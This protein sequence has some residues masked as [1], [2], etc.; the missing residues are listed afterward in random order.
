M[1]LQD[2]SILFQALV[3]DNQDPLMLGRIRAVRLIDNIDDVLKSIRNPDWN[4][5]KDLWTIRDPFVWAPLI[6][7]FNY[8]VPKVDELVLGLF[9]NSDVKYVNQYY[10]QS[11]FYSPTATGFQYYQGA[12]KFTATGVQ[13]A[14]PKPL[15]TF[16]PSGVTYSDK[17][18]HKGV[19][20]EPTDNSV[21]GRGSAD[22][23]VKEE[24]V[25]I[26]A[27][28]FKGATLQPNVVPTANQ[29]RAF[30]Q[31]SRFPKSTIDNPPKTAVELKEVVVGVN[32]LIEYNILNPENVQDKFTGRISLYQLG[33]GTET[34]SIQLTVDSKVPDSLKS[35]VLYE[36]F[37]ALSSG[38]TIN[39]INDFIKNCN[40]NNTSKTTGKVLFPNSTLKFPFYYRPDNS[41]YNLMVSPDSDVPKLR[42]YGTQFCALFSCSIDIKVVNIETSEIVISK[43]SVGNES[44]LNQ[45][46]NDVIQQVT[47][48]LTSNGYSL[49][50]LPTINQLDGTLIPP[51]P[52]N[53]QVIKR[54]LTSI[55]NGIK[56]NPAMVP[57]F[58]L[59]YAQGKTGPIIDN[60]TRK[61]QSQKTIVSQNTVAALG[62]DK[63]YLLSHTSQIPGKGK[64][65]FDDTLYGI[66]SE[67][68]TKE[69]A[70]K[71][72]SMVRGE[73][74]IEL[75]NLIVRFLLT[76]THAF[77]GM[78]P[79]PVTQDG[80]TAQN[81][82]TEMQNALNKVLNTDIKLN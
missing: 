7:Y 62:G 74:L 11:T 26:R 24:E 40:E 30:L 70:K 9:A 21:L 45:I 13:I 12:N 54:N 64:I 42:S 33:R 5:Q 77:P 38:D 73:E 35:L 46:Y 52:S 34:N 37:T 15:K 20:P 25:L 72:S 17:G 19:F 28:K 61:I 3:L 55:F 57:G 1:Q 48:G 66:P 75:L 59:V 65:N 63:I 8:S 4:P 76:H 36:D 23:I 32:Y 6:P 39:F 53:T 43:Y 71:T 58:S 29:Q 67:I 18:V 82:L 10:I 31:L 80:S 44:N 56:L 14:N 41:F 51:A 16:T 60:Q 47:T 50:T 68:F 22:V 81:L 27:G 79:V 49:I 2:N 69:I 78:P